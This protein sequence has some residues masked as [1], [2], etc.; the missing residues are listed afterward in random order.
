MVAFALTAEIEAELL[1]PE[2]PLAELTV[3]DT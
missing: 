2:P 3:A 1:C